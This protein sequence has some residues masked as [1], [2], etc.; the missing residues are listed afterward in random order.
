MDSINAKKLLYIVNTG[1]YDV[2]ILS[3]YCCVLSF[4]ALLF[5]V[6]D[7]CALIAKRGS[8]IPSLDATVKRFR[9]FRRP[10]SP[11]PSLPLT[12]PASVS[13]SVMYRVSRQDGAAA[14]RH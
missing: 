1:Y 13:G 12:L 3:Y 6:S 14:E 4:F 10:C 7:A 9:P 8:D 5:V 11:R 2:T